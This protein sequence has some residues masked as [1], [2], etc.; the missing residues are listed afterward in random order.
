ML[1]DAADG[2]EAPST[3]QASG[4]AP[5]PLAG[6]KKSLG[7]PRGPSKWNHPR[8]LTTGRPR[9]LKANEAYVNL[10]TYEYESA[11]RMAYCLLAGFSPDEEEHHAPID[12]A[13]LQNV[14]HRISCARINRRNRRNRP[15]METKARH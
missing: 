6:A 2:A 5:P 11:S 13:I 4:G 3:L 15:C 8:T 7:D 12:M 1:G 10:W 14:F 9:E